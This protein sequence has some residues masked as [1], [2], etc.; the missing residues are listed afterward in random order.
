ME[1]LKSYIMPNS[2][3][4]LGGLGLVGLG[5]LQALGVERFGVGD[6][7]QVLAVLLGGG[8]MAPAGYIL[9]GLGALGIRGKQDRMEGGDNA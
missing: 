6:F 3:G 4:R 8:Q 9:L 1:R 2:L 7:A 5:V